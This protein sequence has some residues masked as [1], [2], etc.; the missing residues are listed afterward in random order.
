M[1]IQA[2]RGI[3]KSYITSA[4]VLWR[5]LYDRELKFLIVSAASNL[6]TRFTTQTLSLIN[7]VPVLAH[8]KPKTG[9]RSS[10]EG[11]DV[12]D[13]LSSPT[14]SVWSIGITG[15]ITGNRADIVIADDIEV[16]NNSATFDQREKLLERTSEFAAILK[17]G[18]KAKII[19]L[20]TPQSEDSIYRK[21]V[22]DRAYLLRVYPALVPTEKQ[23][24]VYGEHLAPYIS[25][26]SYQEGEPTDPERFDRDELERKRIEYS[27]QGFALQFMLDT[28]LADGDK[29]PLKLHDFIVTDIHESQAPE[30][31][32]VWTNDKTF[33]IDKTT[34]CLGLTEDRW[35]RPNRSIGDYI[36]YTGSMMAID[37]A[38]RGSQGSD[39]LAYCVTKFLNG[40]IYLVDAGGIFGNE[41]EQMEFLAGIAKKHDVNRIVVEDYGGGSFTN[42]LKT[43]V[44]RRH[45]C[46][47][48]SPTASN[49]TN[50]ERRI[51]DT[52]YP[53]LARHKL[54]VSPTV[55]K[56]EKSQIDQRKMN[57]EICYSLFYQ[58]TRITSD[59][60]CLR[61][62]DRVDVLALA[63]SHWVNQLQIDAAHSMQARK[64]DESIKMAEEFL[65]DFNYY[66]PDDDSSDDVLHR[67]HNIVSG[68][69]V[70][71]K[72]KIPSSDDEYVNQIIENIK[73]GIY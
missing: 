68:R 33:V 30:G 51:I 38:G 25:N 1:I 14:P 9:Q 59:K 44:L 24:M 67:E 46:L 6:A 4:Y 36:D 35:Y 70:S 73:K 5:L 50:K 48:E 29:T 15:Q 19:Y 37:P 58:L 22:E 43:T 64:H 31:G 10:T 34:P 62:D 55:I 69:F 45:S 56:Q 27:D 66:R 23:K 72:T 40:Y 41:A 52:L 21:L 7:T 39:E 2:F 12:A 57:S 65:E 49:R 42:L 17:T 28:S 32:Y 8:L 60:G 54:I 13:C 61:H 18:S 53:I 20:G 47:I 26:I 3:G 16:P 63:C 11:F 71:N